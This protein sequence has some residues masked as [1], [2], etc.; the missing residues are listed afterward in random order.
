VFIG[1]ANKIVMRLLFIIFISLLSFTLSAQSFGLK[2]GAAMT[3][4]S[5]DDAEGVDFR[6]GFYFGSFMKLGEANIRYSPEVIFH[7][8]GGL[9]DQTIDTIT[10]S[11]E[12]KTNY[13][14]IAFNGNFHINDELALVLGPYFA[15]A[16]SGSTGDE[17]MDWDIYN[18]TEFGANIGATYEVNDLFHVDLRYGLAFTDIMEAKTIKNRSIQIGIGYIFSY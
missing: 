7:Q 9:V 3:N 12:I 1:S 10:V 17:S 8:K 11:N 4:F 14:D 13:V 15:Y 18:K 16:F 5:G 2:T 6:T